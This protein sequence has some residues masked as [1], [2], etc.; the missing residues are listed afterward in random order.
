M[1][2]EALLQTGPSTFQPVPLSAVPPGQWQYFGEPYRGAL[3][4]RIPCEDGDYLL[5]VDPE[6]CAPVKVRQ[7]IL[8]A[9]G[10]PL[11]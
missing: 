10:P 5:G 11:Y 4:V 7:D 9:R 2:V 8:V 1:S 6:T 3:L